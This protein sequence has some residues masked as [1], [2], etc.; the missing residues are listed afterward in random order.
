MQSEN[1]KIWKGCGIWVLVGLHHWGGECSLLGSM[2]L[3][4]QNLSYLNYL[5][6]P[7]KLALCTIWVAKSWGSFMGGFVNLLGFRVWTFK[8]FYSRVFQHSLF[9]LSTVFCKHSQQG[10][11]PATLIYPPC[12][13][14]SYT[15]AGMPLLHRSY[16]TFYFYSQFLKVLVVFYLLFR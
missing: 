5:A 14:G 12:Y 3:V 4:C 1:R 16:L 13:D 8:I 11:P 7:V 15:G 2:T 10:L 6:I 9:L